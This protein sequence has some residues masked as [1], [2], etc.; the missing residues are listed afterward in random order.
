MD[1]RSTSHEDARLLRAEGGKKAAEGALLEQVYSEL[2]RR[3]RGQRRRWKGDPSL[4]TTALVHEAYLRLVAREEQSWASRS[5]FFAVAAKAMRQILIDE[6]RRKSREKRGGEVPTLSLEE[7]KEKLGREVAMTEEDAEAFVLLDEALGQFEEARPRAARVVECRF[8][9][10]MT[11]EETAEALDI[12]AST[13]SRDWK[14]GRAWLYRAM[15]RI[16]REDV[17]GSGD[18]PGDGASA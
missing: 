5:H 2:R 6:A 4:R 8:F 15:K 10:G 13:V 1:A 11:I 9:S 14:L 12:S 17:P 16:R 7:L 18:E 3:A